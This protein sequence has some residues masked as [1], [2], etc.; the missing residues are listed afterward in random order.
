MIEPD[1]RKAV[2]ALH[3][4]GMTQRE[5]SR[6][7]RISRNTVRAIIVQ[8]G[9]QPDI[10]RKDQKQIDPELLQKLYQDC[11]G[12]VQRVHEKLAEEHGISVGYSTLTRMLRKQ[13]L[14]LP[15][16]KRCDRVPD[17]PGLEMQHDTTLYQVELGDQRTK[18]IASVLYLRYS[19]RRYLKFYR[20]FNRFAMKCFLHEALMY[21]GYAARQCVIDNTNLARLRGTG[22]QAVIVPEMMAFA[23]GY[24]FEFLCHEIRHP[25][26]KA[27]EERSFWTVETNFLPGRQ[28][29]SLEDLNQQALEWATVRM[30]HRPMNRTGLI[31]AKAFEHERGDLTQ[32]SCHLPAPYCSEGRGTDQYGFMAWNGN[33]FWVPGNRREDVRV[34]RYA[35]HLK[36]F[37]HGKCVAEYRLPAEGVK[38][39]R[40]S[41]E[42]QPQPRHQPHNRKRDSQAEETRL[43]AMGAEVTAY[44]EY[45]VKTQGIQ[46]HRFTRELFALSRRVTPA[47]FLQTVQRA[48]RYRITDIRVVERI[49]WLCLSQSTEQLP[50]VEVSDDYQD[51]PAYLEGRLTDEPD[52]SIYDVPGE[53]DPP[54]DVAEPGHIAEPDDVAE[55]RAHDEP[56]GSE[57]PEDCEDSDE[58]HPPQ[59]SGA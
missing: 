25:N 53:D 8:D 14:G 19:K 37:Q 22:R 10:V 21:W 43:H 46:R 12:W 18:V 32:L 5:I 36:I 26:R 34:F 6:R 13:G 27:G 33:Y 59:E 30:E 49:A 42:G 57:H 54:S 9:R 4:E 35:E 28:F 41:P 52:L 47:A 24:G 11:D 15:A 56:G 40:I 31:P 51:R 38:N 17:E 48:M 1:K 39:K 45:A 2:F 3:T 58:Q 44:L 20:V 16:S 55:T 29:S 50:E 23:R 7:L